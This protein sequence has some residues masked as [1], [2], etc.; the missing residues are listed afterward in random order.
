[1][2]QSTIRSSVATLI[3]G[4]LLG[5]AA[6]GW[7]A[8]GTGFTSCETQSEGAATTSLSCTLGSGNLEAGNVAVVSCAT[9]NVSASGNTND[10]SPVTDSGG[11]TYTKAY[12]FT[13][14]GTGS[15]GTGATVSVHFSKLTT[16]LNS[17]SSTITCN[18]ASVTDKAMHVVREFTIGAGNTVSIAGTPV[19][20]ESNGGDA[21]SLTVGSLTSGDY[22]WVRAIATESNNANAM[23]PTALFTRPVFPGDGCNNTTTGG[24]ASDIGAC[25]EWDIAT[26]T[27]NTSDPT[28][29]DTSNDN[30]SVFVALKEEAS[31]PANDD[32]PQQIIQH[33][34]TQIIISQIPA[35]RGSQR[36][37]ARKP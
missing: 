19:G 17:G 24:E 11:N 20:E 27:T 22:L 35:G 30:A 6:P 9:D 23:T 26:G 3:V 2:D 36:R 34:P 25:S 1:M 5:W 15:A 12:E 10:H 37:S 8:W 16:Q 33:A 28:L 18:F 29:V 31:A 21:G 32:S 14:G 7:A 4:V 13:E